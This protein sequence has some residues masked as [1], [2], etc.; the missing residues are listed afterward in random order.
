MTDAELE[1]AAVKKELREIGLEFDY[2][3]HSAGELCWTAYF[4]YQNRIDRAVLT[5]PNLLTAI[6]WTEGRDTEGC[7]LEEIEW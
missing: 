3:P 5:T 1:L 7:P 2:M 6:A 4:K